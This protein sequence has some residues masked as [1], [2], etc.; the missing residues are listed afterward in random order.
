MK[1][2]RNWIILIAVLVGIAVAL[3]ISGKQ[4]RVF[5]DNKKVGEYTAID[6]SYSISGEKAKKIKVNKKAMVY[7]KGSKH[8]LIIEFKDNTGKDVTLENEFKLSPMEDAT[9]Y[10][11]LLINGEENWIKRDN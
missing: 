3:F 11:P 1:I 2:V 8:K 9:I 10:L 4:H 5:I 6:V 7:V